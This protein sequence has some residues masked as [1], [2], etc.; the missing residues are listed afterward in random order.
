MRG[1]TK[2]LCVGFL[3]VFFSLV[4][5]LSPNEAKK[6]KIARNSSKLTLFGEVGNATLWTNDSVDISAFLKKT[7]LSVETPETLSRPL[8]T[9]FERS[10]RKVWE[11]L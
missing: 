3:W 11:T 6:V 8:W 7:V 1:Q 2:N 10:W 9:L 4:I 5:F